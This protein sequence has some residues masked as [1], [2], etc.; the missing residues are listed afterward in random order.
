MVLQ[1]TV[2]GGEYTVWGGS[3]LQCASEEISLRH[4]L[5]GSVPPPVGVCNDGQI[6]GHA[7]S[8]QNNHYTSQLNITLSERLVGKNVT[9]GMDD[10]QKLIPVD[11]T[12]LDYGMHRSYITDLTL[13]A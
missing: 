11:Y 9:C 4:A 6:I 3:A 8:Q 13:F 5:F 7:I 1:C 10:G 2:T 12:T